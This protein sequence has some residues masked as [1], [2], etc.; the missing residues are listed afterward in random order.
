MEQT[1]S[2][3]WTIS[4]VMDEIANAANVTLPRLTYEAFNSYKDRVAWAN[5]VVD[6]IRKISEEAK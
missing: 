3:I 4:V 1:T 2:I 6:S 5:T